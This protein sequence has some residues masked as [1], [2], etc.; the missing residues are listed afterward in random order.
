MLVR[1]LLPCTVNKVKNDRDASGACVDLFVPFFFFWFYFI[2][3]C[4]YH[5]HTDP[6]APFEADGRQQNKK[7]GG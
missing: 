2:Q 5:V 3:P 4:P 1:D 7:K 6:A